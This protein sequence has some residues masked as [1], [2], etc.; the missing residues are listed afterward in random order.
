MDSQP[1]VIPE[2]VPDQ[3]IQ[4]TAPGPASLSLSDKTAKLIANSSNILFGLFALII[5]FDSLPPRLL[6]PLWLI[7]LAVSLTNTVSFPIV[8]L[9]LVH[10]GAALAP[11]NAGINQRRMSL[12]RLAAWASAAYLMLIPLLGFAV[13][14]GVANIGLGS[15]RQEAVINR[16][17]DRL[18]AAIAKSSTPQQLQQSMVSLQGPSIS[19]ADLA[20][21]LPEL[22]AGLKKIVAQIRQRL[23]SQIP[24]PDAT[25]YISLYLQALR[26]ALMAL[27]CSAGFAALSWNAFKE[28][29][30]LGLL[31][32]PKSPDSS[33]IERLRRRLAAR[34]SAYRNRQQLETSTAER[35]SFWSSVKN[36]EQQ[37]AAKREK[38]LKRHAKRMRQME[39]DRQ[40]Q[41]RKNKPKP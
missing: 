28:S 37:T 2:E 32:A 4:P 19:D 40:R 10:I 27:I 30:L 22:K 3:S 34:W 20:I 35:R 21:P 18:L 24:R 9:A 25:G 16:G 33:A 1:P 29:T 15:K 6:D 38:D 17:A 12:S 41:M 26:A 31:L 13:W 11:L 5:V 39:L 8:G 23:I 7:G 14:R 36:R